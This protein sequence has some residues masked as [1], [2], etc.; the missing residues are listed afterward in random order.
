MVHAP[1]HPG[2]NV[3]VPIPMVDRGRVD[4]RNIMGVIIDPVY[5]MHRI[6]MRAGLLK[7]REIS[8]ISLCAEAYAGN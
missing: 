2:D 3:T 6:A 8:L 1:G 7:I 4:P 5:Y